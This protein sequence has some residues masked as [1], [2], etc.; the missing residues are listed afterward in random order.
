MTKFPEFWADLFAKFE[1]EA[2]KTRKGP[3][4]RE[5]TYV[6]AR[7]VMNRLDDVVGP[8]N[9]WDVYEHTDKG[10]VCGLTIRLPDGSL[11]TKEDGAAF[12]EPEGEDD[13]Y[14]A[15]CSEAFKRAAV[16]FGVG[17]YLYRDRV[18]HF[19]RQVLSKAIAG[20]TSENK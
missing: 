4:G 11:V 13:I 20:D 8:E 7:T 5:L 14:K 6:T 2:L 19:V 3:G 17:R 10:L 9:W 15:C 1:S 12:S 16:K 18:P